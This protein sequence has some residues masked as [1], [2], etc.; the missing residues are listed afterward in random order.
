MIVCVRGLILPPGLVERPGD[1]LVDIPVPVEG[2]VFDKRLPAL[3]E[4]VLQRAFPHLCREW[5][6]YRLDDFLADALFR[7]GQ[8]VI[9]DA[10]LRGS[11]G[12]SGVSPDGAR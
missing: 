10:E 7:P 9:G 2:D 3:R 1:P 5:R 6:R 8:H 11:L 12:K 4:D